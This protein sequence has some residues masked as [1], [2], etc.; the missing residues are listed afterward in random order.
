MVFGNGI[1]VVTRTIVVSLYYCLSI[2][3]VIRSLFQ[4]L[5]RSRGLPERTYDSVE[6]PY[7]PPNNIASRKT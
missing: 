2:Y 7:E 6:S 3:V 1:I 4:I 5:F